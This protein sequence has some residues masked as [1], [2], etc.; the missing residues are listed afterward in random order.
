M[1]NICIKQNTKQQ[2]NNLNTGTKLNDSCWRT[3]DN[4]IKFAPLSLNFS[5]PGIL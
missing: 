4:T 3:L 1:W 5:G 2:Q